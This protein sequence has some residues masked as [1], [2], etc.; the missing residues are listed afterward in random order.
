[1]IGKLKGRV[2]TVEKDTLLLDVGGVGYMVFCS[3]RTLR[4]M[5]GQGEAAALLIETHVREDHIH[6]YGFIDAAEKAWFGHLTT[7]KGVGSKVAL[8]I[9]SVASPEQIS[10]AL[11]SKDKQ[12]FTQAAGVGPKLAERILLELKEKTLSLEAPSSLAAS[13]GAP[14]PSQET[15]ADTV[16]DATSA[17]VNLGY[18]RSDAYTA[19]ATVYKRAPESNVGELIRLSL[20]EL[21]K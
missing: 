12:V 18:S 21:S 10:L 15:T 19:A 16:N 17:L 8:A 4:A 6:L 14:N 2:D 9:L 11:A 3:S 20:K 1:M 7:V 13:S 5:P